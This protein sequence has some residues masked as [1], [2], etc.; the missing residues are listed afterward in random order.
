LRSETRVSLPGVGE[1]GGV[2]SMA[3]ESEVEV[4]SCD[5]FRRLLGCE[6]GD[7]EVEAD[8]EG[9]EEAEEEGRPVEVLDESAARAACVMGI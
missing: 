6:S 5:R 7:W 9:V 3:T 2:C 4:L 1:G 8:M